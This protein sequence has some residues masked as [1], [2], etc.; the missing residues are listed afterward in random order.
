TDRLSGFAAGADDYLA[1]PFAFAELVARLRALLRRASDPART[2]GDL[3]LDPTT[4]S[5][6]CG[7]ERVSLSPT[8][9]RLLAKLFARPSMV[10]RRRELISAG[11]PDG[12]IVSD[13]TL[14]QYVSRLRRKLVAAGSAHAIE[15]AR[16]VGFRIVID[17]SP[18]YATGPRLRVRHRDGGH[19][20]GGPHGRVQSC[21]GAPAELGRGRRV[22]RSG[23]RGGRH[24]HR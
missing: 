21:P 4:H 24:R 19:V 11:W 22:A 6:A 10:L 8:E 20:A 17:D 13:N 3:H 16:G 5:V 23:R 9:F 1:K 2:W 14:D 15:A 18:T 12:A 7:P